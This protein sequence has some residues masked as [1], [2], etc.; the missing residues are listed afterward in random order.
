MFLKRTF[1]F[2]AAHNLI[3]YHGKC[4]ALHGH[5]YRLAVT[6]RGAPDQEGMVLDF[7]EFKA[8]VN[9]K[10]LSRLDH[11][12]LND[13][14]EQPTAEFIARWVWRELHGPL[15]RSNC[16][17]HEI[18]VWETASSSVIIHREDMKAIEKG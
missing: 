1:T 10:V 12:Y 7:V 2:D 9:E 5:T 6:L 15:H 8:I 16:I 13:I 14:L 3:H 17:L 18:E 11:A 4:E